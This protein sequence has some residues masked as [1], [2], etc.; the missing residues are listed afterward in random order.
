MMKL[1]KGIYFILV[2][3]VFSV[4]CTKYQKLLKS[5]DWTP[6]YEAAIKYYENKD[7]ARAIGLIYKEYIDITIQNKEQR[8]VKY[9]YTLIAHE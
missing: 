1:S 9:A 6:K 2:A 3:S 5:A 7:Y 4:G 8:G